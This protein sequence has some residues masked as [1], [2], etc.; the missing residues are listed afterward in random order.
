MQVIERMHG[1]KVLTGEEMYRLAKTYAS[2]LGNNL[3]KSLERWFNVV[4]EIPYMDDSK[5]MQ[6]PSDEILARPK[7]LLNPAIFPALDC[8]KKAILI[9]AW[10]AGQN[11]PVPFRFI[12]VSEKPDKKIH[13]VFTQVRQFP[14]WITAD[15]TYS[16]YKLGEGKPQ[17]TFAQE[18]IPA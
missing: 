5:L 16:N 12:A 1:G 11:P 4:L 8:K 9:G 14:G 15:P 6:N 2:D 17:T 7:Y 3:D 18:L 13:H 10:C